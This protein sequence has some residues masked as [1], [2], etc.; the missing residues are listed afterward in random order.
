[1][2]V[3]APWKT[4]KEFSEWVKANPEKLTWGSVGPSGLSAYGIQDW[5][6][7]IGGDHTKTKMVPTKGA[8]DSLTKLAGNH[9]V[10]A[11]HTVAECYTLQKAGKIR[12]LAVQAPQ[13]SKYMPEAPTAGEEGVKGLSV[14]WWTG[15]TMRKGTADS[16]VKK[17]ET[18]V[19]EM[20]K[21]PEFHK[22][23]DLIQS[24]VNYLNGNDFAKFIFDE[25]KYYTEL[26]KRVGIR[27]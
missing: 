16:I 15:I 1:V 18:T 13:R 14:I 7:V 26:A 5:L 21:D 8:A 12:V 3:E 25:A 4:F 27:K 23:M 17:W 20:A 22:K 2:N 10:L 11:C 24:D 9:I 19:E 6:A